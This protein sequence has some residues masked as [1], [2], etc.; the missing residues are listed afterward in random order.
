MYASNATLPPPASEP[1]SNHPLQQV[2]HSYGSFL[3]AALARLH[4]TSINALILTGY[5]TSI[6][7][8][9]ASVY[10]FRSS[11]LLNPARFPASQPLGYVSMS[12]MSSR[13]LTFFSGGYDP[14][15][16][17]VDFDLQDTITT[18]EAVARLMEVL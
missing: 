6:N 8:A 2:G 18:G 12:T 15:V 9:T 5:S 4:P 14:A 16:V 11:S 13:E 17:P 1:H 7:L 10:S 3:G